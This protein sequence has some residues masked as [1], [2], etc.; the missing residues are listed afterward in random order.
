MKFIS[1]L[2]YLFV[3]F[4]LLPISCV[5]PDAYYAIQAGSW[6]TTEGK[7]LSKR[8]RPSSSNPE[9]KVVD[10]EYSYVVDGKPYRGANV[11]LGMDFKGTGE[12]HQA[13][14]DKLRENAAV[15]VRYDPAD[16]ANSSL[17]AGLTNQLMRRLVFALMF[18]GIFLCWFLMFRL[19]IPTGNDGSLAD[20]LQIEK[21]SG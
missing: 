18:L 21:G 9:G 13:I 14:F 8:L 1:Y 10:V 19:F 16:P 15:T 3:L 6:P 11:A 2:P 7:L 5:A 17:G 20:N 4:A 12:E